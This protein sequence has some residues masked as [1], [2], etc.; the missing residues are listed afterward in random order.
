MISVIMLNVVML[1]VVAAFQMLA[2]DKN[3][4]LFGLFVSD[5]VKKFYNIDSWWPIE[6]SQNLGG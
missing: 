5:E 1:S 3:S 6:V 4:S 2:R